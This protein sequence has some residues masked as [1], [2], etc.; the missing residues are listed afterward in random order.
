MTSTS[1]Q[2]IAPMQTRSFSIAPLISPTSKNFFDD[3]A[4]VT[5]LL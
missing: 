3:D 2:S 5:A 1:T 4:L